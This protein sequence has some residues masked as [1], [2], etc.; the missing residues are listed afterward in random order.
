MSW[1]WSQTVELVVALWAAAVSRLASHRSRPR[2]PGSRA[3]VGGSLPPLLGEGF[4]TTNS[5]TVLGEPRRPG[6]SLSEFPSQPREGIKDLCGVKSGQDPDQWLQLLISARPRQRGPQIFLSDPVA[7]ILC[8][9]SGITKGKEA[10]V[11]T[12]QKMLNDPLLPKRES[13]TSGGG[14]RD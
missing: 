4:S 13:I 3:P 7:S 14:R 2:A 11:K 9:R 1:T 6:C 12:G 8:E 10:M 5:A